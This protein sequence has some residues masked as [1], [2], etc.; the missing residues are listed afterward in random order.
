TGAWMTCLDTWGPGRPPRDTSPRAVAILATSCGRCSGRSGE[1]RPSGLG[2]GCAGPWRCEWDD[3]PGLAVRDAAALRS[4]GGD[5]G[6]EDEDAP[7]RQRHRP[8][9]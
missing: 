9:V 7:G 1:K 2:T 3:S 5:H 6:A 8:G 4:G